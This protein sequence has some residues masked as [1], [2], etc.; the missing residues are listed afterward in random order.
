MHFLAD[1]GVFYCFLMF[2]LAVLFPDSSKCLIQCSY[3]K[4]THVPYNTYSQKCFLTPKIQKNIKKNPISAVFE[5]FRHIQDKD[6]LECQ[7]III[8]NEHKLQ[9]P[10]ISPLSTLNIDK[11]NL[12]K[13]STPKNAV[14]HC[15]LSLSPPSPII[16]KF[17]YHF[18]VSHEKIHP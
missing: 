6:C 2:R 9:C 13:H 1:F 11:G 16:S 7:N 14:F 18:L 3:I 8:L 17:S 15:F 5:L 4:F 12:T 10:H